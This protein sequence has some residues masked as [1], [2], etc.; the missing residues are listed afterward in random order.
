MRD[1][2]QRRWYQSDAAPPAGL[3]PLA[4]LY[5][6]I[7]DQRKNRLQPQAQRVGVPVIVV[8]NIAVGG[9]GKTPFVIWLVE[10]LRAQGWSPGVISRG[11]GARAPSY[12]FA[13]TRDSDPAHCGDEPLLIA[14]RTGCPVMVDPNR[15]RA[16][17]ALIA[18]ARVNIIVSDDGL[19]HYRLA[20]DLEFC[21]VDGARGLGN[22]ALIP[23]GPLRELA[24]R[25]DT[26]DW[27][28]INGE[29]TAPVAAPPHTLHMRLAV[30]RARALDGSTARA[31]AS[32]AGQKVHAVAGIGRPA[33]FFETLR[34]AGIEPI[35]HAF[36]DH[37][38][39]HAQELQ[40]GDDLPLLM[41]E[42]DAV[43]C[44]RLGLQNAFFVPVTAQ[45]LPDEVQRV[46]K[47][48]SDLREGLGPSPTTT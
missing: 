47:S 44:E 30:D 13:V 17:R 15:V 3:K 34:A 31:L 48:A 1:W 42:K 14:R 46:Q 29:L 35:E 10:L 26:V 2:L 28:V 25:L 19:Q 21:L 11:Y 36:A 32:F 16:A 6:R 33:R 38:G 5:G 39:Y 18:Q 20:R 45:L 41:T 7:A 9:T 23:A 4:A 22:G 12:P 27:V 43:K 37:H 40:F 8:G 24:S